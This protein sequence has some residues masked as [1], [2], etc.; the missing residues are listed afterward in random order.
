MSY[1]LTIASTHFIEGEMP[2]D[3][4]ANKLRGTHGSKMLF[5]MVS[6]AFENMSDGKK[7]ANLYPVYR[8][9]ISSSDDTT[10]FVSPGTINPKKRQIKCYLQVIM[11]QKHK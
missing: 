8:S 3:H 2:H 11:I 9:L 4:P 1:L 7:N 5:S 6:K 10:I